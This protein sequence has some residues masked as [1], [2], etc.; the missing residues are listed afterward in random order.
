M[1]KEERIPASEI[2]SLR[3]IL[4]ARDIKQRSPPT[5]TIYGD[6]AEELTAKQLKRDPSP[7]TI[8]EVLG[9]WRFALRLLYGRNAKKPVMI[10]RSDIKDAAW[11]KPNDAIAP[12]ALRLSLHENSP[13]N[14]L[15]TLA[16]LQETGLP[17]GPEW[18]TPMYYIQTHVQ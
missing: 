17:V 11:Y 12:E 10:R 14:D 16:Q 8:Q 1:K 7:N 9:N 18:T 2:T 13:L 6:W 3:N 5:L 15:E 4:E